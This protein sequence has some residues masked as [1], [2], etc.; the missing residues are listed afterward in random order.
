M[1]DPASAQDFQAEE[2]R[3]RAKGDSQAL[4]DLFYDRSGQLGEAARERMLFQA[5]EVAQDD[6]NDLAQAE[7]FFQRAYNVRKTYARA[8]GALKVL[9]KSKNNTGGLLRI[10]EQERDATPDD[11]RRGQLSLEIGDLVK[12]KDPLKA[13]DN[14]ARAIEA[15]PK[16]RAPLDD[17]EKLA[18]KHEKFN[19]LV[20]AYE[21]LAGPA[22]VQASGDLLLPGRNGPVREPQ[23][24]RGRRRGLRRRRLPL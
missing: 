18:R 14:Y 21:Q 5:G 11:Q 2:K 8:L 3:L 13:L 22:P 6:L 4:I 17:L 9:Y 7:K 24:P 16:S 20:K 15:W 23:G 10:L 12:A 1:G 19:L